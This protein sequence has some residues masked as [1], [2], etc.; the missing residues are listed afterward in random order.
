MRLPSATRD[1]RKLAVPELAAEWPPL[2]I[3]SRLSID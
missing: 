3:F 1:K 2:K